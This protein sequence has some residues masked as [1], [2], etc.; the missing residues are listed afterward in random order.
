M[1][2]EILA[3]IEQ[4]KGEIERLEQRIMEL[5]GEN[6]RLW[7]MA[8]GV[9]L[10]PAQEDYFRREQEKEREKWAAIYEGRDSYALAQQSAIEEAQAAQEPGDHPGGL[11]KQRKVDAALAEIEGA[12]QQQR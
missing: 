10:T 5:T 2:T 4:N 1:T 8:Y 9:T 3:R 12:R 7:R 6:G 11:H